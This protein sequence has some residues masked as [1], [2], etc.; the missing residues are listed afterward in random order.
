MDKLQKLESCIIRTLNQLREIGASIDINDNESEA[1][2]SEI[3]KCHDELKTDAA[4]ILYN[5]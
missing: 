2:F 5:K 4:E 3:A 1:L